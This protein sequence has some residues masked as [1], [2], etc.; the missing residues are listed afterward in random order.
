MYEHLEHLYLSDFSGQSEVDLDKLCEELRA[1]LKNMAYIQ[2]K[3]GELSTDSN[4]I[5][6]AR[7][8]GRSKEKLKE[9][10]S[11]E[12]QTRLELEK[13]RKDFADLSKKYDSVSQRLNQNSSPLVMPTEPINKPS[14]DEV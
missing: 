8:A 2:E 1:I 5:R 9:K 4:K 6:A 7:K 11:S 14:P 13:M 12:E 10:L 3:Y